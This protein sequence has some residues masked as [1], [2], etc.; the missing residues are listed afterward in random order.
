MHP[1]GKCTC[2][3]ELLPPPFVPYSDLSAPAARPPL[4]LTP[5]EWRTVRRALAVHHQKIKGQLKR[6]NARPVLG[7]LTARPSELAMEA[8]DVFTVWK[9]LKDAGAGGP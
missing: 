3:A 7:R 1:E 2:P 5:D 8:A 9:K 6:A 4:E